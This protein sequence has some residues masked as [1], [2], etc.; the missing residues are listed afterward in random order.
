YSRGGL[1]GL[2]MVVASLTLYSRHKSVAAATMIVAAVLILCFA[3]PSWMDRMSQFAHGNLDATANQRLVSWETS[4][5][6]AHDYPV[7][8]GGFETLPDIT[9]YQRYQPRALP[10][11]LLSSGPHS[12][13]FQLLA[14]QGF[15]GLGLFLALTACCFGTLRRVRRI[16]RW[17]DHTQYLVNY[18]V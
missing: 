3:P 6:F 4:W 18:S 5:R 10:D 17:F 11:G 7:M 1:L 15:V 9:I 12:I 13:Y 2:A 16:A 8:G 14:D